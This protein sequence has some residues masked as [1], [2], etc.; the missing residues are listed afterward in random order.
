M[1]TDIEIAQAT[2]PRNI[3]E[4]AEI[5]GVPDK[6]L[7]CYGKYKAKVDYNLLREEEHQ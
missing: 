4:I 2:Q 1:L 6:Y 7:E 5:A 3:T